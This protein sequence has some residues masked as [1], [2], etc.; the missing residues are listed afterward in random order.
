[1]KQKIVGVYDMGIDQTQLVLREGFGGEFW[2][3]PEKGHVSRI[4]VGADYKYWHEV[5]S[6][7]LHESFELAMTRAGV[8]FSPAPDYGHDM[9]GYLF[10]FNH[11]Q[12][13]DIC[14]RVGTYM[15]DALPDLAREWKKWRR[16]V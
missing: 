9:A 5:V 10:A 11:P 6:V 1:M 15:S 3:T 7:L 16:A 4:K 8:R 13:S 12:Y 14:G 2:V